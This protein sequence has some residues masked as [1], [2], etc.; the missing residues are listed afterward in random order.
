MMISVGRRLRGSLRASDRIRERAGALLCCAALGFPLTTSFR[1]RTTASHD[2]EVGRVFRRRRFLTPGLVQ[3]AR[4]DGVESGLINQLLHRVLVCLSIRRNGQGST[5]SVF[6]GLAK[7]ED[8]DQ[9]NRGH[10]NV[11]GASRLE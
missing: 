6:L 11:A 9:R 1:E 7:L 4:V 10:D 5:S 3:I 8:R 2:T